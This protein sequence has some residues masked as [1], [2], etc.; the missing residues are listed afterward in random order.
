MKKEYSTPDIIFDSFAL[1]ENI[2]AD[3]KKNLTNQYSGNC[4]LHLGV[5]VVFVTGVTGC[6]IQIPDGSALGNGY[7]YMIPTGD[8]KLFNS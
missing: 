5:H 1:N 8:M 6:R 2:A 3:C 7:C 4:G